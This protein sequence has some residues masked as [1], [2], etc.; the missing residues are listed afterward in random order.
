MLNSYD[1]YSPRPNTYH[2][3][4]TDLSGRSVVAEWDNNEMYVVEDK[5]ATNYMLYKERTTFTGDN[6]YR[7]IHETIDTVDSMSADEAME[8]LNSVHQ[9]TRWS[10]VY[11]LEKLSI[12]VCFNENYD[13]K[14]T[15]GL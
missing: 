7:K 15:E 6:R 10:A 9:M 1:M 12:D 14:W 3:F 8:L 4:I 5:A 11:N 2:I 13:K